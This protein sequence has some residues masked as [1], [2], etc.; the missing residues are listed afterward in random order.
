MK[1]TLN[2]SFYFTYHFLLKCLPL[3]R[4]KL[5]IFRGLVIKNNFFQQPILPSAGVGCGERQ[6]EEGRPRLL[7]LLTSYCSVQSASTVIQSRPTTDRSS[8][9]DNNMAP[10]V[11]RASA[12]GLQVNRPLNADGPLYKLS[13]SA[14]SCSRCPGPMVDTVPLAQVCTTD[15]D[16]SRA[17]T[18]ESPDTEAKTCVS[19]INTR[20][21][22]KGGGEGG[23][24]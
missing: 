18:C 7:L 17:D 11:S 14:Y 5:N 19:H 15:S 21:G 23:I 10:A 20:L 24:N 6:E 2:H 22:R 8:G 3:K 12:T 9:L 16:R 13:S 1:Q 4:Y